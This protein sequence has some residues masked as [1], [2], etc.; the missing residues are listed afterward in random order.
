MDSYIIA[1]VLLYRS[2][3]VSWQAGLQLLEYTQI[4]YSA[5]QLAGAINPE[6]ALNEPCRQL[7]DIQVQ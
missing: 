1:Q 7:L 6:T 5:L 3:W 2:P 4:R